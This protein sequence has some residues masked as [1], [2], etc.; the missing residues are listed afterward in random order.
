MRMICRIMITIL[1]GV[2]CPISG[3]IIL[4]RRRRRQRR[5]RTQLTYS[6]TMCACTN[7]EEAVSCALEMALC[8]S[9][10]STQA[11]TLV[12]E[13]TGPHP[14]VGVTF[15]EDIEIGKWSRF[16][17]LVYTERTKSMIQSSHVFAKTNT[18][19]KEETSISIY[20][21]SDGAEF[22]PKCRTGI[23]W[24]GE[25]V[26]E[27]FHVRLL[28]G[29]EHADITLLFTAN[30]INIP[31]GE[32][33]IN[34]SADATTSSARMFSIYILRSPHD[35]DLADQLEQTL[36]HVGCHV[37]NSIDTADRVQF[38]Y[39][40]HIRDCPDDPILRSARLVKSKMAITYYEPEI[41]EHLKASEFSGIT[42]E[43]YSNNTNKIMHE[44]TMIRANQKYMIDML[45]QC[46]DMLTAN[47]NAICDSADNNAPHLFHVWPAAKPHGI[48][49]LN[50]KNWLFYRYRLHLLCEGIY[51]ETGRNEDMEHYV[52]DTH[53]G[54]HVDMPK[55]WFAKWGPILTLAVKITCIACKIAI[56]T[57]G[58]GSLA[59]L[60]P[61]GVTIDALNN[62]LPILNIISE[63]LVG[64][65]INTL[66]AEKA[67]EYLDG[68]DKVLEESESSLLRVGE[69]GFQGFAELAKFL[70]GRGPQPEFAGLKRYF[71]PPD[72][73]HDKAGKAVWLCPIHGRAL[74]TSHIQETMV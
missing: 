44:L 35:N 67:Q 23:P 72:A 52:F 59:N 70:E 58:G 54:Y 66:V 12:D 37:T 63:E 7:R 51:T 47:F 26:S 71:Y 8:S 3:P 53:S 19:L 42:A 33:S 9:V 55:E 40:R 4:I 49:R 39:S 62:A 10:S 15:P 61:N 1:I 18:I 65:D 34:I 56:C 17:A 24:I 6:D 16:Q 38:I 46:M 60:M 21:K 57:T 68:F 69:E 2:T 50:P 31:F 43:Y 45:Q 41:L 28:P 27:T 36:K 32:V 13:G 20:P 74:Q 25:Y 22:T 48:S 73:K 30:D 29:N 14:Y 5:L 11:L 64:T